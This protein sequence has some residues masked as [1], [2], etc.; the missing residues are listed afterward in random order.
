MVFGHG[1]G[2]GA[3]SPLCRSAA[4]K[5]FR[6]RQRSSQLAAFSQS[7]FSANTAARVSQS[8]QLLGSIFSARVIYSVA[9]V[10]LRAVESGQVASSHATLFKVSLLASTLTA[11]SRSA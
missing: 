3:R 10:P 1:K 4:D 2:R 5:S 8:V 7:P 9:F 6:C 11:S